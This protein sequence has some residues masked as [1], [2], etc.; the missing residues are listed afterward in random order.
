[1]NINNYKQNKRKYLK[2][3]N[4]QLHWSFYSLKE[5]KLHKQQYL[6]YFSIKKPNYEEQYGKNT[7]ALESE[8]PEFKSQL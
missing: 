2:Q 6:L 1:M 4:Y 5:Y 3:L 7:K 8:R